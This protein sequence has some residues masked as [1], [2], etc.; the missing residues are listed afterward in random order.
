MNAAAPQIA[1]KFFP[2]FSGGAWRQIQD[3]RAVVHFSFY[4]E[5]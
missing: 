3:Y 1:V 2:Q 5:R 4:S